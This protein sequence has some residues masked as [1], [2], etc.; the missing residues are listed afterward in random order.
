VS[1]HARISTIVRLRNRRITTAVLEGKGMESDVFL[2]FCRFVERPDEHALDRE[3][4]ATVRDDG[5]RCLVTVRLS[6]EGAIAVIKALHKTL[7]AM[8][9]AESGEEQHFE[10]DWRMP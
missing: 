1:Q 3:R 5:H 10:A 4:E 7:Q 9:S 8:H 2:Q 6:V